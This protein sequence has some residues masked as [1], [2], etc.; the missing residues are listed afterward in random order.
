MRLLADADSRDRVSCYH[1]VV[2][3]VADTRRAANAVL[4]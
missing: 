4:T 1:P 2:D 3:P